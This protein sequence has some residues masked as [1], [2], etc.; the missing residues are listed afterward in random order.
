MNPVY[1]LAIPF[2][3]ML[4]FIKYFEKKIKYKKHIEISRKWEIIGK[5]VGI[6]LGLLLF[7]IISFN[8][9]EIKI[10]I[11]IMADV[12]LFLYLI[13]IIITYLNEKKQNKD[14]NK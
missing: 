12:I 10:Y 9:K 7:I 4:I 6:I 3:I 8:F 14:I 11:L 5:I 2:F 13:F 1:L